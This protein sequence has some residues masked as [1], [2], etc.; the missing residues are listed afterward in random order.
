MTENC[1]KSRLNRSKILIKQLI[2]V[3]CNAKSFSVAFLAF[4]FFLS[5]LAQFL[6]GL[7]KP[8]YSFFIIRYLGSA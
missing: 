7:A 8:V 2:V 1:L 3:A 6:D 4:F 5:F